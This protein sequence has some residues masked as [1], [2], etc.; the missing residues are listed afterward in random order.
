MKSNDFG[1]V[2]IGRNEGKRLINCLNS[3]KRESVQPLSMSIP[4]PPMKASK[5]QSG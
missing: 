5:P 3:V 1:I 4:V 2:V